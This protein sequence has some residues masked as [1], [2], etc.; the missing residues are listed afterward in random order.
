LWLICPAP[1]GAP[2]GA[3]GLRLLDDLGLEVFYSADTALPGCD[4]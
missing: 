1:R 2:I 4:P 3:V